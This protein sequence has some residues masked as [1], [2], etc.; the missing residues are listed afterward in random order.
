MKNSMRTLIGFAFCLLLGLNACTDHRPNEPA[1]ARLRLKRTISNSPGFPG[2]TEF[3][4]DTQGRQAAF[5]YLGD[6]ARFT[7]E[8]ANRLSS[9]LFAYKTVVDV[10]GEQTTFTYDDAQ[11]QVRSTLVDLITVNGQYTPRNPLKTSIYTFDGTTNLPVTLVESTPYSPGSSRVDYQSGG[12]NLTRSTAKPASQNGQT[13]F[14][15]TYDSHPNPFNGLIGPGITDA[16]RFSTNNVVRMVVTSG[17]EMPTQSETNTQYEYNAQGLPTRAV[18]GM[19]ELRYE[20]E[21]Y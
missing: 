19:F 1:P 2:T 5:I 20:Y 16:R 8:A 18:S 13:I 6:T 10:T 3:L 14:A 11:R 9:I 21:T 15:Y 17:T 4:Y 12:G 7:Y